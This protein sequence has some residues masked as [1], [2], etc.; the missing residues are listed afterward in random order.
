MG[1]ILIVRPSGQLLTTTVW[2]DPEMTMTMQ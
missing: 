1:L 2:E